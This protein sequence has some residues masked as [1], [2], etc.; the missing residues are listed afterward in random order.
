M[1]QEV[2]IPLEQEVELTK[3][4]SNEQAR[5]LNYPGRIGRCNRAKLGQFDRAKLGRFD[6]I[7]LGRTRKNC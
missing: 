3:V 5:R 7:E 4:R 2:G 6:W 1:A